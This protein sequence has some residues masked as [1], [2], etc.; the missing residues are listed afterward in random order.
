[1]MAETIG[2]LTAGSG[3]GGSAPLVMRLRAM[4]QVSQEGGSGALP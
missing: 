1:M 3:A 4:E 2:K